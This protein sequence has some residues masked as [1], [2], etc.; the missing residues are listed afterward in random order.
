MSEFD[1][2]MTVGQAAAVLGLHP[3]TVRYHVDHANLEAIRDH[4]GER[5]ITRESVERMREDRQRRGRRK[6]EGAQG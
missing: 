2:W 6:G 4:K 1:Q 3:A 5:Q